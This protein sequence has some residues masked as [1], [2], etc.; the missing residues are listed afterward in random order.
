MFLYLLCDAD[1]LFYFETRFESVIHI[2]LHHHSHIVAC[3]LHNLSHDLVHE[4]HTVF[5]R[6]SVLIATAVG[7]WREELRNQ[8][9]MTR[10]N[11]NAVKATLAAEVHS[12]TKRL[13]DLLDLLFLKRTVQ[14]WRIEVETCTCSNRK[15][16]AGI[17]V[18][19]I[20]AVPQLN[21][22]FSTLRMNA[23]GELL[24]VLFDLVVDIKLTVEGHTRTSHRTVCHSSH[25]STT[26]GNS[27]MIIIKILT[28]FVTVCHV[29]KR[30]TTDSA[31]AQS[32]RTKLML[33]KKEVIIHCLKN[34][35]YHLTA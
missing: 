12:M 29:L 13:D 21:T 28:R 3:V 22:S 23:I 4:T 16:V 6:A 18:G 10:V 1:A 32:D 5:E 25:R 8:I 17:E 11:L 14:G 15:A 20:T 9:A 33:S 30:G 34:I 31:V 24:Q 2:S 7:I 35:Q 27:G 26:T 19:H